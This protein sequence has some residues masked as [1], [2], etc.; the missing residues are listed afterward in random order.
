MHKTGTGQWRLLGRSAC[1]GS[2][3]GKGACTACG[4]RG[5]PVGAA[6]PPSCAQGLR[7]APPSLGTRWARL[8]G[9]RLRWA[10]QRQRLFWVH[11]GL[12]RPYLSKVFRNGRR[13][14]RALRPVSRKPL[15]S[16]GVSGACQAAHSESE[17]RTHKKTKLS[18]GEVPL[19]P[20]AWASGHEGVGKEDQCWQNRDVYFQQP[21][22][23]GVTWRVLCSVVMYVQSSGGHGGGGVSWL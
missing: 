19:P 22:P 8:S 18:K 17:E 7:Q 14:F 2:R 4:T 9:E 6:P 11:R 23:T 20:Q 16:L 1:W 15:W 10:G 5:F 3:D 13:A 12:A 21:L